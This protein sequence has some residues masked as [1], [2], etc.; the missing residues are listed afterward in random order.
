MKKIRGLVVSVA[1]MLMF[2]GF[3]A[4][5]IKAQSLFSTH[6]TGE[7]TLPFMT[8]WGSV[9]LPPGDYNLYYGRLSNAGAMVVEVRG[10][11]MLPGGI[12]LVKGRNGAIGEENSLVCV[13][14][15]NNAYVRGLELPA[16]GES[17]V[18]S[19]PRGVRVES[20]IVA[21]KQGAK[22]TAQMA[23]TRIPIKPA[24]AK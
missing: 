3:A 5:G 13:L 7:F 19:R 17:A 24:P 10:Q 22:G 23:E 1:A 12:I 18:F 14:E 16:I 15:G 11:G 6:F 21:E 4:T 2:L 9:I 8:Q 20:W